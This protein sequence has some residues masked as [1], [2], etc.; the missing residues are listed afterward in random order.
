MP[1]KR[2]VVGANLGRELVP[3]DALAAALKAAIRQECARSADPQAFLRQL[4]S[5]LQRVLTSPQFDGRDQ[6]VQIVLRAILAA[7]ADD[8]LSG[9]K[10]DRP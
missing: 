10:G 8:A 6:V 1:P 4:A 3:R 9:R 2:A 5:E 7:A